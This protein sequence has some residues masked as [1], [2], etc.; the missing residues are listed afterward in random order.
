MNTSYKTKFKLKDLHVIFSGRYLHREHLKKSGKYLYLTPRHIQKKELVLSE[1]DKYCDGDEQF[2]KYILIPGDIIISS[3]WK[4][5]KIYQ[6]KETD[7]PAFIGANWIVLRTEQNDY[8][9]KYL[10]IEEFYKIFEW[11]CE[12]RL[13][14]M[15]IPF[16]STNELKEI[17]I[18]EVSE[19]LLL[20]KYKKE[21]LA[22]VKESELFSSVQEDR[23]E[24]AQK[25]FIYKL[26]KDHYADPILKLSKQ[27]ES[28]HL[29]FKSSFRRDIE[30]NGK[31]PESEII[32]SV[33]KTIG[34]FCNTGGGDLLIGVSDDN[35]VVGIEVDEF[36]NND[37]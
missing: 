29:E 21:K 4:T 36:D 30:K 27:S 35:E 1:K 26:I 34:G 18:L 14:L 16:L 2:T 33:L 37:K 7:P 28:S 10:G 32:H 6:Y 20:D 22:R 24:D 12:K 5:R 31:V 8:L 9:S 13:S 23:L 25:E 11:D 19:E 3:I 15:T 17:E